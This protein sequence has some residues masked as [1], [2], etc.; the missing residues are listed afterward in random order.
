[1][2]AHPI[3]GERVLSTPIYSFC[4]GPPALPPP[5]PIPWPWPRIDAMACLQ[6]SDIL[7]RFFITH[8]IVGWPGFA[9]AQWVLIS[10]AHASRMAGLCGPCGWAIAVAPNP[11]LIATT[12]NNVRDINQSSPGVLCAVT[13][14]RTDDSSSAGKRTWRKQRE[15]LEFGAPRRT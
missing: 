8:C 9:S 2:P 1:M 4:F 10:A 11:T 14:S 13:I 7:S 5:I 3:P 15:R 6:P 12:K